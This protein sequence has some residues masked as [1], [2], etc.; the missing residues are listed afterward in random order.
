MREK[1]DEFSTVTYFSDDPCLGWEIMKYEIK[2]FTGKYS[3]NKKATENA[4]RN[5]S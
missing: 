1:I 4:V 5:Q 3:I 2:E